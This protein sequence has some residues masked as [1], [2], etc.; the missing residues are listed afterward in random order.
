MLLV[1]RYALVISVAFGMPDF[2]VVKIITLSIGISKLS[3]GTPF[4]AKYAWS[5]PP[6]LV[7]FGRAGSVRL[8][9]VKGNSGLMLFSRFADLFVIG[10][11]CFRHC[12]SCMQR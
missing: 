8:V 10:I 9:S 7:G 2:T 6:A 5:E 11:H 12:Q 1:L 3:V 4:I